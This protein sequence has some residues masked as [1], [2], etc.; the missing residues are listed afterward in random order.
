MRITHIFQ[1]I[2]KE[3]RIT[4]LSLYKYSEYDPN[5]LTKRMEIFKSHT[6][7]V[8]LQ[9]HDGHTVELYYN[10]T[11]ASHVIFKCMQRD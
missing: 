10:H 6:K 1:R 5:L 4:F 11:D 3:K 8:A 7:S 2:Y 9:S